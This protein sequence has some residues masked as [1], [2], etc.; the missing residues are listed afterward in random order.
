MTKI[1]ILFLAL[2]GCL[3]LNCR[4]ITEPVEISRVVYI[5]DSLG[6]D[7]TAAKGLGMA[8]IW[9]NR[10]NTPAREISVKPDIIISDLQDVLTL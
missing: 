2:L 10:D 6:R 3:C 8:A 4:T 9:I 1:T 7:I 5:G